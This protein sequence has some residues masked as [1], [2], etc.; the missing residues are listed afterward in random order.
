M[1]LNR[2]NQIIIQPAQGR[3]SAYFTED[4]TRWINKLAPLDI[5]FVIEGETG[6]G[7]DTFAR[8]LYEQSELS[9]PFI[10]IN[11]AAIPEQLAEAEFFGAVPGAFTGANKTRIGHIESS[12]NGILFLDEIDSMPL[13]LQAKLLR[14]IETRSV[15]PLGSTETTPVN[16]RVIGAA[17]TPL[18]ELV[19]SGLFR[20][21]LYFRLST[22]K[23][24][25][26]AI[27]DRVDVIIPQFVRFAAE[28]ALTFKRPLPAMN[29]ALTESLLMH[30]WPGN[31]RELKAAAM[32]F[33]LGITPL[34]TIRKPRSWTLKERMARIE[35]CLIKDCLSRHHDQVSQ[36]ADELGIPSRTLYN[37]LKSLNLIG[38]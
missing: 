31:M 26:P 8:H 13:S 1:R 5:D 11:C 10:G 20:R 18:N 3:S 17:Q 30:S 9:G 6:T 32:R 37:K 4:L 7:K 34:E 38:K 15:M 33:V 14:V 23:I 27:R 22:I 21:D 12:H 24:S 29:P 16:L 2:N 35:A 28:A 36:A 19:E 25:L